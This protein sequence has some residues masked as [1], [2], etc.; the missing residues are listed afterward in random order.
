MSV[1]VKHSTTAAV[2]QQLLYRVKKNAR[3]RQWTC[4]EVGV[5]ESSSFFGICVTIEAIALRPEIALQRMQYQSKIFQNHPR[6]RAKRAARARVSSRE[7]EKPQI[8]E[9]SGLWSPLGTLS[10]V[11]LEGQKSKETWQKGF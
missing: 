7:A 9:N 5:V 1:S 8:S 11:S 6:R 10:W 2:R 4:L 3:E